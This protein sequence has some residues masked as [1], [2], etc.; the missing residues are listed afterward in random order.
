MEGSYGVVENRPEIS[1][2]DDAQLILGISWGTFPISKGGE[3]M[4]FADLVLGRAVELLCRD[5]NLCDSEMSSYA[6]CPVS[7]SCWSK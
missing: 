6:Q 2:F 7:E 5:G 4:A 3:M 1:D